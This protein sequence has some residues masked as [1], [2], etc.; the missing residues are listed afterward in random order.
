M[1]PYFWRNLST[2]K[3]ISGISSRSGHR[4]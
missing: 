2:I 4:L 3:G 1:A